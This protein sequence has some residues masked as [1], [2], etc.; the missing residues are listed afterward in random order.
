MMEKLWNNGHFGIITC[1]MEMWHQL[2]L[3]NIFLF[4]AWLWTGFKFL[5]HF[6]KVPMWLLPHELPVKVFSKDGAMLPVLTCHSRSQVVDDGVVILHHSEEQAHTVDGKGDSNISKTD[7][8]NV[9]NCC[10]HTVYNIYI[11]INIHIYVY[12]YIYTHIYI[13]TQLYTHIYIYIIFYY[14]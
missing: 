3:V 13:Y 6:A 11:Y 1:E 9:S 12:I 14:A 8:G 2:V 7:H 5:K 4:S 10:I